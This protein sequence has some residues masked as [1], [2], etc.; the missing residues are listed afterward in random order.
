LVSGA[1]VPVAEFTPFHL[2]TQPA[3]S[4]LRALFIPSG[5]ASRDRSHSKQ[6]H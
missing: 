4:W 6:S 1:E 5:F 2:L 3:I